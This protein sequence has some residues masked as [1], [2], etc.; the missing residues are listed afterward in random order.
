MPGSESI[1][2]ETSTSQGYAGFSEAAS[3]GVIIKAQKSLE[4]AVSQIGPLIELVIKQIAEIHVRP[5]SMTLE[6]GL[7]FGAKG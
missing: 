4:Q 7:K 3:G 6:I 2:I 5:E 1:L